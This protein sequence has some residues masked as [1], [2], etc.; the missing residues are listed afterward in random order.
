MTV[1]ASSVKVYRSGIEKRLLVRCRHTPDEAQSTSGA[2]GA[3]RPPWAE[4]AW[5][6]W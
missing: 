3:A 5:M 2:T 1:R 6:P 4:A